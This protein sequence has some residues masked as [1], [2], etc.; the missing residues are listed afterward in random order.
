MYLLSIQITVGQLAGKVQFSTLQTVDQPGILKQAEYQHYLLGVSFTDL[1]NGTAVGQDGT[2]LRT[3]NGGANWE[4]Q[5][6]GTTNEFTDVSFTDA[7]TG[8]AVG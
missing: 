4:A 8:I 6:S 1:N 3:T 5:S 7:N 2:I